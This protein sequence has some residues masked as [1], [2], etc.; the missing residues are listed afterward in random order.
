VPLVIAYER[1]AAACAL[2]GRSQEALEWCEKGLV[3]AGQVD[4]QNVVRLLQMRGLARMDLQDPDGIDDLRAALDLA[5]GLGIETGTSYVNYA[6]MLWPYEPLGSVLALLDASLEF[7]RRRGLTHHEMWTRGA[8][9]WRYYESGRWDEL[10]SEADELRR[11]DAEGGGTQIEV[12][13]SGAMAP[14]LVHRGKLDEALRH[15]DLFLPRSREIEDPQALIPAL[16]LA[17]LAYAANGDHERALSLIGEYEH[18]TH[19]KAHRRV[20]SLVLAIRILVAI[21]SLELA[22]SILSGSRDVVPGVVGELAVVT[23]DAMLAEAHGE[24]EA[25]ADLHRRAAAGWEQWGFVV[26][27]AYAL[28]GL[29]RCGDDAATAQAMVIFDRLGAVPLTTAARAA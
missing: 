22:E 20:E 16:V 15:A 25:A 17:A 9:L 10:L 18:A 7:A 19:D 11:W 6:E 26:E 21:G 8:R 5:L 14:V 3:L 13:A 28:L 1:A 12:Y 27:W 24:S 29:G 2:G 4:H 23:A